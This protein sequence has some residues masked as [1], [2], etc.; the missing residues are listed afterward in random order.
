MKRINLLALL[1]FIGALVWVFTFD[2][3][4]TQRIQSRVMALFAP[5]TK[6]GAGVQEKL[7]GP[8]ADSRSLEDLRAE[9][10]TL[11]QENAR[12]RVVDQQVAELRQQVEQFNALFKF[13]QQ[14]AYSLTPAR[15]VVRRNSAWYRRATIDKGSNQGISIGSPVIVPEGL[16]GRVEKVSPDESDILFVTDEL[17]KVT[18]QIEG[19]II[20][21]IVQG[22]RV[23]LSRRANIHMLMP[24]RPDVRLM[25]LDKETDPSLVGRKV[26]SLPDYISFPPNILL[27]TITDFHKGDYSTE[28][29]IQ[30]AVQNL[31]RL[32]YVFVM[33]LGAEEKSS[34]PAP[35]R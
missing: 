30:P 33:G 29:T 14:S 31:D 10:E 23:S 5:F 8:P 21:G 20:R 27:G 22:G 7:A 18:A 4:T 3:P 13:N 17:C 26:Y 34:P 25:F 1:V 15:I 6:A 9:N 24:E 32:S 12:L 35:P 11:T 19:T 16:V 2:T 28:A